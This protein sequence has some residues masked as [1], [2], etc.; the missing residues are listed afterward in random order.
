MSQVGIEPTTRGLKVPCSAT[1]LLAPTLARILPDAGGGWTRLSAGR[2]ETDAR[3]DQHLER[4]VAGYRELGEG[5]S[6]GDPRPGVPNYGTAQHLRQRDVLHCVEQRR[7][8][9]CPG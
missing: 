7:Q 4:S 8:P 9:L 2:R 6:P 1:E 5:A 3:A